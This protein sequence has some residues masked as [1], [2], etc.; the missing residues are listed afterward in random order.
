MDL[1]NGAEVARADPDLVAAAFRHGVWLPPELYAVMP[2]LLPHV[3]RDNSCRNKNKPGAVD[4]WGWPS[5]E[6]YLRD[7]NSRVKNLITHYTSV[8]RVGHSP[9]A[10]LLGAGLAGGYT[11]CHVWPD[12][13]PGRNT[14]VANLVWLPTVVSRLSDAT[15]GPPLAAHTFLRRLACSLFRPV[16]THQAVAAIA[17]QA[18]PFLAVDGTIALRPLPPPGE[19]HWFSVTGEWVEARHHE[20]SLVVSLLRSRAAQTAP[21]LPAG[22]LPSGMKSYL[23]QLHRVRADLAA[24]R[25]RELSDYYERV[26]AAWSDPGFKGA[27]I[28][29]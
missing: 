6:G 11:A 29:R 8:L 22:R 17:N 28:D 5:P 4:E 21:E 2:V 7:D 3:L 13:D 27:V 19:V 20:L 23:S 12:R 9:D 1:L 16:V 25:A 18:W 26:R 15:P 14:F 10:S 24:V